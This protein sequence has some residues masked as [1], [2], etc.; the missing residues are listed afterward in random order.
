MG[1]RAVNAG[2]VVTQWSDSYPTSNTHTP[3]LP[4]TLG[5]WTP[6]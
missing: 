1:R 2:P 4:S 5:Q 3:T 6:D